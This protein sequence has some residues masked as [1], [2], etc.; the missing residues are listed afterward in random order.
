LPFFHPWIG[1]GSSAAGVESARRPES[2]KPDPAAIA[3]NK[4]AL[5]ARVTV[6]ELVS[7]VKGGREG[8]A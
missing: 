6:M 8:D 5:A 7:S 4:T 1:G 2:A 3:T